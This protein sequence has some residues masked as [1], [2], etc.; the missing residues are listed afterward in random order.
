MKYILLLVS[1]L[2][3]FTG[4]G[5]A[6]TDVE[7]VSSPN[8]CYSSYQAIKE[9]GFK[10]FA[11]AADGPYFVCGYSWANPQM[12]YAVNGALHLCE[13]ARVH[14]TSSVSGVRKVMT[15]CRVY[16]SELIE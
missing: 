14:P 5:L 8:E 3:S 1:L 4:I 15:H 16:A 12:K 9:A 2:I 13:K 6:A 11:I 7:R 10:A